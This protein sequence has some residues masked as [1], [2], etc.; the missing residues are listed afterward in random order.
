MEFE[1]RLKTYTMVI[2]PLKNENITLN[3]FYI[4]KLQKLIYENLYYDETISV[5]TYDVITNMT[6]SDYQVA[7]INN[8]F[9]LSISSEYSTPLLE[10][11][12]YSQKCDRL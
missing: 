3:R 11:V 12:N 5:F 4:R 10:A 2:N 1:E 8:P 9:Q 7:V 6:H